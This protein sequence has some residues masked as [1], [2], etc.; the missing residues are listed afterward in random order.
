MIEN[1]Q[2]ENG[3]WEYTESFNPEDFVGFV[4]EIRNVKTNRGYIGKKSF[5]STR[6]L[7]PLKGKKR[8]RKVTKDSGWKT[9]CSSSDALQLDIK[10]NPGQ[11]TYKILKLCKSKR[12]LT[13]HE[14]K[15]QFVRGVLEDDR[16]LNENILGK[17]FR[18][19]I[20]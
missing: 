19:T 20:K 4:Y 11:H 12:E 8:N 3:H 17:F 5:W 9:Y 6:T 1:K 2:N 18:Q 7:K 15:E 16:Y 14:T 13:Y 10:Q